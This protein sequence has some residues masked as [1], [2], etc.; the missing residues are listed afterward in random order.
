MFFQ[1]LTLLQ[2]KGFNKNYLDS[3]PLSTSL[4]TRACKQP[5][6]NSGDFLRSS[7]DLLGSSLKKWGTGPEEKDRVLRIAYSLLAIKKRFYVFNDLAI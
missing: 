6:A 1:I 5:N 7:S 3:S 2:W 4:D